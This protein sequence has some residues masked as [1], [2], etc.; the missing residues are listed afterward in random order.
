MITTETT[1]KNFIFIHASRLRSALIRFLVLFA[2]VCIGCSG[3][4]RGTGGTE[5]KGLVQRASGTPVG[6]AA[7]TL[8]GSGDTALTADDGTFAITADASGDVSF[9]INGNGISGQVTVSG[10]PAGSQVRFTISINDDS[11]DA[12]LGDVQ[13]DDQSDD[14]SGNDSGSDIGDDHG[15]DSSGDIGDDHGSSSSDDL[16]DDNGDSHSSSDDGAED[17]HG[18]GSGSSSDDSHGGGNGSSSSSSD[19]SHGGGHGSS[20]GDGN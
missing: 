11:G 6:G 15:S 16:G 17:S 12:E 13:I 4:T 8:V 3:G 7:V 20:R 9:E 2:V 10:V 18:G 19:D 14:N 1:S 5:F